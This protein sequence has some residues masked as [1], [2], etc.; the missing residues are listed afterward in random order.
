M[1]VEAGGKASRINHKL[2]DT[3]DGDDEADEEI[4]HAIRE[5]ARHIKFSR[6]HFASEEKKKME[7][8]EA[9]KRLATNST[10]GTSELL[11]LA[12]AQMKASGDL[13]E[14]EDGVS[15]ADLEKMLA[16]FEV[17]G[18]MGELMKQFNLSG[19][20]SDDGDESDGGELGDMNLDGLSEEDFIRMM[21]E[22]SDATSTLAVSP[23][24]TE[25]EE[26]V[27]SP[28][29]YIV[30]AEASRKGDVNNTLVSMLDGDDTL[31]AAGEELLSKYSDARIDAM[32]DMIEF[33]ASLIN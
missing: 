29:A 19:S 17:S 27:F 26:E 30:A 24:D 7:E 16:D 31:V 23:S 18:D 15:D 20:D 14:D 28:P 10:S 5:E 12:S 9:A 13:N 2:V 33:G 22:A 8:E 32:W 21:S 3:S 1:N 4:M 6:D 11:R 25:E